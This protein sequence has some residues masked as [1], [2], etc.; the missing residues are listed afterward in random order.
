[1]TSKASLGNG[2]SPFSILKPHQQTENVLSRFQG[3]AEK[4]QCGF[5]PEWRKGARCQL[6]QALLLPPAVSSQI[7]IKILSLLL[8]LQSHQ[9]QHHHRLFYQALFQA[10]VCSFQF[11]Q[12]IFFFSFYLSLSVPFSFFFSVCVSV[13]LY[14][15][16]LLSSVGSSNNSK[17][18][19]RF[20]IQIMDVSIQKLDV[21]NSRKP[22]YG[23]SLSSLHLF[24]SLDQSICWPSQSSSDKWKRILIRFFIFSFILFAFQQIFESA[25][26]G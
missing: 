8:T 15:P 10:D 20:H 19:D 5:A 26:I 1:M 22:K 9:Y 13:S 24:V 12:I 16:I 23:R 11:S 6:W 2:F 17:S 7:S 25:Q 4:E 18:N 3:T 14:F 21:I